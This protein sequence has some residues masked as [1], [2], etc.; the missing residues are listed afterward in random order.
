MASRAEARR[1]RPADATGL[2]APIERAGMMAMSGDTR[3][4]NAGH[5]QQLRP[6]LAAEDVAFV[7][8]LHRQRVDDL[9]GR[10]AGQREASACT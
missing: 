10:R 1:A 2:G 3:T 7:A 8:I 9:F 4:E 6:L 5:D